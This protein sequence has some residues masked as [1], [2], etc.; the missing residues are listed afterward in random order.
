MKGMLA[1]LSLLLAGICG[2]ASAQQPTPAAITDISQ[3]ACTADHPA[4]DAE[5]FVQVGGIAQWI[6]VR[7]DDCSNPIVLLLHG[8]PGNPM[9]PYAQ[10]VYAGWEKHYTLVQWDQRGAGMT[11]GRNTPS[12]DTPL[13]LEQIRDDGLEVTQFLTTGLGQ[14]RIIVMGGSWSSI[15]AVHMLKARP[16]LFTAYLGWSQIVD[17]RQNVADT[18]NALLQMARN[19]GDTPSVAKLESLGAPPW[20]DPRSFGAMRRIDRKYEA[21]NAEPAP[22][23]WWIQ[24]PQ[25]ATGQYQA[26]YEGGEE[27]SYLQ[28]VGRNGD[29]MYARVDLPALGNDFQVPI[30]LLQGE[31]DLLTSITISRP[32][33]DGLNA[34]HKEF[35]V[36][37]R[38]NHDPNQIMV[39]AQYRVLSEKI[40]PP[41][42]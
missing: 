38:T 8:G 2:A 9:S 25:Y 16:D 10:A 22:A 28:F 15:I 30:Y 4:L 12:D 29:G 6:V 11:Y 27:Y 36:L 31:Q 13:S 24:A 37:P 20:T 5:G 14:D 7:G 33:F 21:L 39:D 26:D 41:A 32:W 1:T 23:H 19:A 34:P 42:R 40:A 18:Y 35:I 17:Y 3:L